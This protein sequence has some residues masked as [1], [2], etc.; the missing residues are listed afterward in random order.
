MDDLIAQLAKIEG[1]ADLAGKFGEAWT[2]QKAALDAAKGEATAAKAKA[3]KAENALSGV[4]SDLETLR[5]GQDEATK[6]LTTERE[7]L[8]A[9]LEAE[10][11]ARAQDG[12]WQDIAGRLDIADPVKRARALKVLKAEGLPETVARGEDGTIT[13]ADAHL[14]AFK[15]SMPE[16]WGA[17]PGPKGNGGGLPGS[18]AKAAKGTGSKLTAD[19]QE[20]AEI[21]ALKAR[22]MARLNLSPPAS[23]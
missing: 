20:R 23:A 16:F 14:A 7:K 15:E 1:D 10:R 17:A 19:Q 9:E 13:G 8:R 21:E 3:T 11:T 2:A 12:L 5:A 22:Q 4:T 6:A 18:D